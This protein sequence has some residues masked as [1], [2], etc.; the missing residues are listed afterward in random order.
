[1]V[2]LLPHWWQRP[3]DFY[4][5][6][7]EPDPDSLGGYKW[8]NAFM[9]TC[10]EIANGEGIKLALYSFAT[11]VP[12]IDEFAELLPSLQLARDTGHVLALHEYGLTGSM[13]EAG[14]WLTARYREYYNQLL[15]PKGLGDLPLIVTEA[16]PRGGHNWG[17]FVEEFVAD[18][19]WYDVELMRDPYVIGA[20]LFT[21]GNWANANF[22]NALYDLAQWIIAHPTTTTP[23]EPPEPPPMGEDWYWLSMQDLEV[24]NTLVDLLQKLGMT[25]HAGTKG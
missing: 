14:S 17:D 25:V 18:V 1:M 12:E 4:E 2:R 24:R 11:G 15:V 7:N 23:P 13:R 21:L 19:G 3:A 5:P 20:A 8:L 10:V 9:R 22:A 6:I 16:A